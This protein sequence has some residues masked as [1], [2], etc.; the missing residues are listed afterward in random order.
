[1]PHPED[2]Q[3]HLELQFEKVDRMYANDDLRVFGKR[4]VPLSLIKPLF[5][6]NALMKRS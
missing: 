6:N 3:S 1:M 2:V 5:T 4:D